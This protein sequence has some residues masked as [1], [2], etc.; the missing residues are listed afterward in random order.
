M[1]HAAPPTPRPSDE[2][3]PDAGLSS[4]PADDAPRLAGDAVDAQVTPEGGWRFTVSVRSLCEFTAKAGDLD[5][6][7]TPSATAIEGLRG[8]QLVALRRGPGYETE[9]ALQSQQGGLRVRGRAD[10]YDPDRLC[11]E[12]VKTIRGRPEDLP[13][14]RRHLHW[15]Q[16]LTYGALF[17]R[18]R[19]CDEL[20]LAL[21]Y[22]DVDTQQETVL[23]ERFGAAALESLFEA[24]CQAFAGW[25]R[26]EAEHRTRRDEA[27]RTLAFPAGDFRRG[28]RTLA[29]AVYRAA[30]QGRSLLCEAPTGI[31]KTVGTLFPS[32]RALPEQAIDKLVF[33]TCKGSA[34][35]HALA[36]LAT[37]RASLQTPALRVVVAVAKEQACEHPGKA[38]HGDAC[39]LARGFF[40]RLA[41]AREAAVA[42]GWMDGHAQRE[43]ALAHGICPY[44]LGQELLRWGDVIVADVHHLLDPNGQ[45]ASLMQALE[46]RVS[47]LVD[48][49]HNLVERTR[50]MYG[51]EVDLAEVSRVAPS[52]PPEVRAALERW[53]A[54]AGEWAASVARPHAFVQAPPDELGQ[55]LQQCV[56]V[57]SDHFQRHPLTVGALLDVHF[58]LHRLARLLDSVADASL[59]EVQ[60]PSPE[61][62]RLSIRCVVPASH[63]R[64]RWKAL[65]S[66]V[67]FSATLSPPDYAIRMLGLPEDTVWCQVG[68]V[69]PARNLSVRIAHGLSTRYP[70][71]GRTLKALVERIAAQFDQ[72]PGNYLAFFSSFDYLDRVADELQSRRPD[73]PQWRQS[74]R[75]GPAARAEFLER[76]RADGQ[77]VGFAVLGGLFAEGVDLPG[78]RLIGAFIATMGLA[79]VSP[80]LEATKARMNALFGPEQRYADWVPA[81]QRVVQAAGRIVRTPQDCGV[82]WLLDERYGH[83]STR[84]LLPGAWFESADDDVRTA[85]VGPNLAIDNHP[86]DADDDSGSELSYPPVPI[87][88]QF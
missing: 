65:H 78:R 14:N 21:V 67:L 4:A 55:A 64:Q 33:L 68:P 44:Y 88:P 52:A 7:F 30:I 71:R 29:E 47:V 46:W 82:L 18:D 9:V 5:R 45:I 2:R 84:R 26:T 73:L 81:M 11:L 10:G 24:R 80:L 1:L 27:L 43:I 70:D 3:S 58:S 8:Q 15:A 28:Q 41:P 49:A 74:P 17:C 86:G 37:L 87:Y 85:R 50:A 75:M 83:Q 31:G 12:E 20:L 35:P 22:F 76:F 32:L 63:L 25:A 61:Q 48:E 39:P 40:D 23:Q 13:D 57:L 69:F 19:G 62:A 60:C 56:S 53:Q 77:G 66:L 34:R 42:R 36:T 79:P 38:C 72:A 16:L 6:R 59:L 51:A 54:Q